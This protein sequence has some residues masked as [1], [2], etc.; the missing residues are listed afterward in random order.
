VSHHRPIAARHNAKV[1][2]HQRRILGRI[3][4][5]I[6][7]Y[8]SGRQTLVQTLNNV[9]GLYTAAEVR[10]EPSVEAFTRLY[11]DLSREDDLRQPWMPPGYSSEERLEEAIRALESWAMNLRADSGSGD[12]P[13]P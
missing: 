9:W 5:Q 10:D 4:D 12:I 3:P 8:R 6:T 7:E 13:E 11:Y 2:P 1:E